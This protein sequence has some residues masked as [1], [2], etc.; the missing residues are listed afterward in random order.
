[1]WVSTVFK[2]LSIS[3]L[4]IKQIKR[5]PEKNKYAID[6]LKVNLKAPI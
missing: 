1:M 5:G 4:T 6:C 2:S 3:L